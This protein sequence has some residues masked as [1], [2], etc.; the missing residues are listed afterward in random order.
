MHHIFA[1]GQHGVCCAGY[2]RCHQRTEQGKGIGV[3]GW[4]H[5]DVSPEEA[6]RNRTDF[7]RSDLLFQENRRKDQNENGRGAVQH[8]NIGLGSV[9]LL[10]CKRTLT[11]ISWK[12]ELAK[13]YKTFRLLRTTLAEW[14]FIFWITILI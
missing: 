5:R 14:N 6:E 3:K 1:V 7:Y 9:I 4:L 2:H 10:L 12:K 13:Y 8:G 11:K